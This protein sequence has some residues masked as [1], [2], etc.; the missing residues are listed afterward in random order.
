MILALDPDMNPRLLV[1]LPVVALASCGLF[2]G[3]DVDCAKVLCVPCGSPL[4]VR[5]HFPE[6]QPRTEAVLE[7]IQGSCEADGD[8]TVCSISANRA[9]TFE[10]DVQATGYQKAHVLKTVPETKGDPCCS[11]GYVAQVVDVQLTPE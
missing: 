7:G 1:L 3:D 6:G 8:L 4:V 9:G 11:C 5:L 2:D 10:F